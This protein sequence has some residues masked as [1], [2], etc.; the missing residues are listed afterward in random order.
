VKQKNKSARV[1]PRG[2][3]H[4]MSLTVAWYQPRYNRDP[5]G[6]LLQSEIN[7]SFAQ[8]RQIGKKS[9]IWQQARLKP[10]SWW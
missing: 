9:R 8:R 5:L 7:Q 2:V 3:D 10:K 1:E 4:S 6:E